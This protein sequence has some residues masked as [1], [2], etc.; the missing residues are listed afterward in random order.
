MIP[1]ARMVSC[2]AVDM[3][4][5]VHEFYPSGGNG[6]RKMLLKFQKFFNSS[7]KNLKN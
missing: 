4:V 7:L 6:N 2:T 3:A 1:H 5:H